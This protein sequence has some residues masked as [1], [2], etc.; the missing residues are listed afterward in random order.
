MMI[1]NPKLRPIPRM[2]T[3]ETQIARL[4]PIRGERGEQ[5]FYLVEEFLRCR[6]FP[7]PPLKWGIIAQ[8]GF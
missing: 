6:F 7:Q 1:L 4:F 3:I 8:L 2:S 5:G